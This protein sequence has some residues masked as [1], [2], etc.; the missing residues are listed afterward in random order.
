VIRNEVFSAYRTY[1]EEKDVRKLTRMLAQESPLFRMLK[2]VDGP[3]LVVFVHNIVAVC[4]REEG[5]LD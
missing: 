5:I 3:T 4:L 2:S 1:G